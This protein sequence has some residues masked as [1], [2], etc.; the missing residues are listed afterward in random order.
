VADQGSESNYGSLVRDAIFPET[1]SIM[2]SHIYFMKDTPDSFYPV[3]KERVN[4]YMFTVTDS[5]V[6]PAFKFLSF[7]LVYFTVYALIFLAKSGAILLLLYSLLG[8]LTT[9]I[10]VNI[11]HDATHNSYF[12]KPALNRLVFLWMDFFGTDGELW[13]RRHILHHAYAN[14][15]G[16]DAELA[17]TDLVR[18]IPASPYRK[19]HRYQKY[20]TPFLYLIYTLFW[21]FVRDI[22]DILFNNHKLKLS[23]G[24]RVGIVLK[25]LQAILIFIV[26]PVSFGHLP[27]WIYL[28]GFICMHFTMSM[29]AIIIVTSAH[30]NDSTEFPDPD[31]DGFIACTWAE[32]Q[33]KVTHDFG[34]GNRFFSAM[35]GGFNLHVAHHLFPAIASRH[36]P[37]ITK[38]IQQTA[39]EFNI[40]Y[41]SNGIIQGVLAHARLIRNNSYPL[42]DF[43][44]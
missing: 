33:L 34:A 21:F 24:R 22:N 30:V 17:A 11:F 25:K 28:A 4:K 9:L 38:I 5:D 23:S 26:L 42:R 20:Y 1:S 32:H 14:I 29:L 10:V 36:Y 40:Q 41:S 31:E 35:M 19:Y 7:T 44:L 6:L 13:K 12:R 27:A 18:I 37:A 2:S 39:A 15:P 43:E 8:L 16:H 3:L